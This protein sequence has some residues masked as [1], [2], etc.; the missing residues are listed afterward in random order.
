M[1]ENERDF[2][3]MRLGEM[4]RRAGERGPEMGQIGEVV[5]SRACLDCG[6]EF[7]S[8]VMTMDGKPLAIA[9]VRCASCIDRHNAPQSR[10]EGSRFSLLCP[11][12]YRDCDLAR[13]ARRIKRPVAFRGEGEPE[14]IEPTAAVARIAEWDSTV[15]G[16]GII[17]HSGVGKTRLMFASIR[18][19]IDGGCSFHFLNG[20]DFSSQFAASYS[21]G[22]EKAREWIEDVRNAKILFLDDLDK[23]R[24]TEGSITALWNILEHRHAH[25]M[26]LN[27]TA[28]VNGE[29]F[30]QQLRAASVKAQLPDSMTAATLRR[31]RAI[32]DS[33]TL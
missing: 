21:G 15:R 7:N 33:F 17:G 6:K 18:K 20:A 29:I 13:V 2:M 12:E 23:A 25:K 4:M 22:A 28:N 31:I 27:F 11:V 30:A 1:N 19:H 5:E 10:A 16:L 32:A 14:N 3:H 9:T 24:W 26:T 8:R